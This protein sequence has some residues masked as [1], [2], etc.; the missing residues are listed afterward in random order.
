M[1]IS[2]SLI[3]GFT[4]FN[5]QLQQWVRVLNCPAFKILLSQ[6][7]KS[8]GP[9]RNFKCGFHCTRH[10]V[11]TAVVSNV[12]HVPKQLSVTTYSSDISF[13]W[14]ITHQLAVLL[15][16]LAHNDSVLCTFNWGVGILEPSGWLAASGGERNW[17]DY[18]GRCATP[19][20]P[21]RERGRTDR[22]SLTCD[23]ETGRRSRK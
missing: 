9:Q 5:I 16:L 6:V 21:H 3:Y 14:F 13:F 11:L 17:V 4:S 12:C 10:H 23:T 18:A 22:A 8:V 1:P 15:T 7:F 20:P 19:P 2:H